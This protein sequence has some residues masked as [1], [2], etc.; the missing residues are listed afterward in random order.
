MR[1]VRAYQ[2]I[3]IIFIFLCSQTATLGAEP[4]SLPDSVRSLEF[5][6][7]QHDYASESLINRV[8]RLDKLVFG[9]QRSGSLQARIAYLVKAANLPKGAAGTQGQP[10]VPASSPATATNQVKGNNDKVAQTKTKKDQGSLFKKQKSVADST[11]PVAPEFAR[12]R[13]SRGTLS[14]NM[15]YATPAHPWGTVPESNFSAPSRHD[16]YPFTADGSYRHRHASISQP[17]ALRQ[18]DGATD[19]DSASNTDGNAAGTSQGFSSKLRSI[20]RKIWDAL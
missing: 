13:G 3:S 19:P 8:D 15:P 11:P 20:G 1:A 17:P 7:F 2:L 12:S 5:K 4:L 9:S 14:S 6:F 18:P 10:A 16:N